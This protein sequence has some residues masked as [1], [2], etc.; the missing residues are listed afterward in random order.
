M[1]KKRNKNNSS[2]KS[3]IVILILGILVLF[4]FIIS[5]PSLQDYYR[6]N[7]KATD[8]P[9]ESKVETN[10][11]NLSS[12]DQY[13]ISEVKNITFNDLNIEDITYGTNGNNI[14]NISFTISSK[15]EIDLEDLDYYLE[16]YNTNSEFITRRTLKGKVSSQK[17]LIE[18]DLSTSNITTLD[19]LS[20]SH[21][22]EDGIP[23]IKVNNTT[24]DNTLIS[25]IK[26]SDTYNYYFNF[27]KNKKGVLTR[28]T[29][30]RNVYS[31]SEEE[32][33]N[34]RLDLQKRINKYNS[35]SGLTA[36]M[37]E[38]G[39]HLVFLFEVDYSN[40]VDL[41][42]VSESYVFGS[43]TNANVIAFKMEAEGFACNG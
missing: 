27:S 28:Q 17:T 15:K 26:N 16:F 35:I 32:Y 11:T 6:E 23:N 2:N 24:I 13:T 8:I 43:G 4:G 1:S 31:S 9:K 20:I 37:V 38:E 21:I 3:A 7:F 34:N 25:C 10:D 41:K 30:R 40:G 39:D 12:T 14:I 33:T 42:K 5:L 29:I 22:S 19:K 18:I 36:D